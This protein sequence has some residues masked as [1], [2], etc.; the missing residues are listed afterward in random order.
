VTLELLPEKMLRKPLVGLL[1]DEA[2]AEGDEARD[3]CLLLGRVPETLDARLDAALLSG[4]LSASCGPLRAASTLAFFGTISAVDVPPSV[5]APLRSKTRT[6]ARQEGVR[7]KRET[8]GEDYSVHA[9]VQTTNTRYRDVG[10]RERVRKLGLVGV[11]QEGLGGQRR[12]E[13]QVRDGCR[14]RTTHEKV[15]ERALG[16]KRLQAQMQIAQ[17]EA[18]KVLHSH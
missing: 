1:G 18:L 3:P 12:G 6:C 2:A 9:H 7:D 16:G 15:V 17:P 10:D 4:L 13:Q 11:R 5:S 8:E 14:S